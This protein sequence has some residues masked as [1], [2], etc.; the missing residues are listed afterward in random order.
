ME[1]TS[2]PVKIDK[3]R[4]RSAM[5]GHQPS[6]LGGLMGEAPAF[7]AVIQLVRKFAGA[8][9][10]VLI[11]GE[12][13]SGKELIARAIHYLSRRCDQPFIPLNC[14][15][16]PDNLVESELFGHVRGAFT[17]AR[18]SRVG[19]VMQASGGTLFLDEI[20]ALSTKG[21]VTLLRF[22]QDQRCRPIG[23]DREHF[24]DARILAASNRSLKELVARDRFRNDLLYRLDILSLNVPALRE[25]AEDIEV[26]AQH[27][28]A[29]FCMQ[30]GLPAKTLHPATL[31]W[32]QSHRWPGNVRELE[33]L[34]HRLVL[35]AEGSEILFC[36]QE[37]RTTNSSLADAGM[38]DPSYPTF[39][40]A[41]AH[42]IADFERRYLT[43]LLEA[44]AGNVSNAARLAGKERRTLGK[45]LKKHGISTL[46]YRR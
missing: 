41:K 21:Q 14:G 37:N 35:L 22:L 44:A 6:G 5:E 7:S 11:E 18:H 32:M 46:S 2:S 12:T 25:R 24:C 4:P 34:I 26:L 9:A 27:F 38:A 10:P 16:I 15:A 45:L 33:N 1:G 20:D 36:G 30:Y 31:R 43:R 17:D 42:A 29:R 19:V 13:G 8:D 23:Q 28:V 40:S 39:H 3:P